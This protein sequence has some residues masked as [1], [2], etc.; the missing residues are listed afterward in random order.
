MSASNFWALLVPAERYATER[1]YQ[2]DTLT[3]AQPPSIHGQ[4]QNHTE[5]AILRAISCAAPLSCAREYA[6]SAASSAR[7][8]GAVIDT[9]TSRLYQP[10]GRSSQDQTRS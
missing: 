2:Y 5:T 8:K 4:R 3:L 6:V 9:Y 7:A 1:L 10:R